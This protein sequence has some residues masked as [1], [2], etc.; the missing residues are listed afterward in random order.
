MNIDEIIENI[1]S[2]VNNY[3]DEIIAIK[4]T[5]DCVTFKS[6][7]VIIKTQEDSYYKERFIYDTLKKEL[8]SDINSIFFIM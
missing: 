6:I 3:Y 1:K 7:D 2:Q 4:V 8:V 5:H